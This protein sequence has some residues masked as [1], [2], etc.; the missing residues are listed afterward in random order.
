MEPT[1][2]PKPPKKQY[3]PLSIDVPLHQRA[4]VSIAIGRDGQTTI[5]TADTVDPRNL[6]TLIRKVAS[7]LE[8]G[9]AQLIID[10]QTE[11]GEIERYANE[12]EKP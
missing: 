11:M 9:R 2:K 1:P 6:P 12:G 4:L 5:I 8:A 3:P 10:D 7:E